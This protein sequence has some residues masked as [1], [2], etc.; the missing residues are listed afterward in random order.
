MRKLIVDCASVATEAELWQRYVQLPGV[1]GAHLFGR[2]LDAFWDALTSGG[3]GTL[4]ADE[5]IELRFIHTGSLR[6]V[7]DGSFYEDLI[8]IAHDNDS[9]EITVIIE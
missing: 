9:P 6:A 3:P 2:N 7:R 1:Q 8:R 4:E 5:R